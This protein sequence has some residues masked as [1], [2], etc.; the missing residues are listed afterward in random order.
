M[1]LKLIKL[2]EIT[3]ALETLAIIDWPQLS[4]RSGLDRVWHVIA[5]VAT[6]VAESLPGIS[7]PEIPANAIA[8]DV[9]GCQGELITDLPIGA[10]SAAEFDRSAAREFEPGGPIQERDLIG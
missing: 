5:G 3:G 2:R 7:N 9:F 10:P 8:A 6:R 1:G 4:G